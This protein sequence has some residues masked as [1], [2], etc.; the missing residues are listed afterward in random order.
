MKDVGVYVWGLRTC[1]AR[2][3]RV[4]VVV[5]MLV[6]LLTSGDVEEE[7]DQEVG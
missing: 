6:V 2:A 3:D 4:V 5:A 1:S 7:Q